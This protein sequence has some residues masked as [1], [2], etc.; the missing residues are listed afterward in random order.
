MGEHLLNKSQERAINYTDGHL[1]I[2]AGAGTGKTTVITKKISKLIN[3]GKAI[4]EQILG[5]TFTE[6]AATEM[7]ERVDEIVSI[8]Y[9]EMQISTFHSFCQLIL[10]KYGLHMGIPDKFKLLTDIDAWLLVKKH[11]YDFELDYYRP[12]GNP[13]CHIHALLKHFSKCKDELISPKEYL[14]YAENALLDGGKINIEEKSRLTELANSY[15]KYNQLLLDNLSLDFSDLIFYTVQLFQMRPN[16]LDLIQEQFKYIFV[17]EFQDVNHAQYELVRLLTKEGK[18]RLTVVGDDDQSIYAFRGASVSNILRFKDDYPNAKEI[19]LTENYR[20]GQEILDSA[21]TLI[22]HN[23]PD[24]L[25]VK[26]KINKKL[27]SCSNTSSEVIHLQKDTLENEAQVVAKKI[28]ELK[29]QD[30]TLSWDDIAILVRANSHA[31]VFMNALDTQGIPYEFLSS[32]GLYRQPIVIDAIN[33]LKVLDSYKESSAIYRLLQLPSFSFSEHDMHEF[34]NFAKKKTISYYEAMKRASEIRLSEEGI[35][36]CKNLVSIITTCIDKVRGEK[37]TSILFCFFEKTGYLSFLMKQE[38]QGNRNA[39]QAI[40]HL[41]Q[42]FDY[43]HSYEISVTNS[44]V[45]GFLEYFET[46]IESGDSGKLYRQAD[47][48]DSVNVM[49]VHG[50]KGLEFRHVFVVNCSEERFPTRRHGE[51]IELPLDLIKEVLPEGDYHYQEERRLFY[52][53]MTRAKEKLF[54]TN[55]EDYGGARKKKVS[56]FIAELGDTLSIDH[57]INKLEYSFSKDDKKNIINEQTFSTKLYALPKT[58]SFSQI[59]AFQTCPY[60]YKILYILK[61]PK[62]GSPYFSFGNTIHITLQEFYKKIQERN[63]VKQ[64]LLFD[65]P[66]RKQEEIEAPTFEELI[67]IYENVWIGDW[68]SDEQQRKEYF[69]K[70]KALLKTFYRKNELRWTI[71]VILEGAFRIKMDSHIITGKIDRVD[72]SSD[73]SLIIIDY[74]TGQAKDKLNGADKQQLL[75]YQKAT[76]ELP[77][78][79]DIGK[80]NS[81]MYYYL[82]EDKQVCFFGSQKDIEKFENKILRTLNTIHET[83]F[84]EINM[85]DGCGRCD[86]C[87]LYI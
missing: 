24:R 29:N 21:Y 33:M 22:T 85:K 71:P 72:K 51:E 20:S 82:A 17:D 68:Y 63:S 44:D 25:E 61:I 45:R 31:T 47:M 75:L 55:S 59:Q 56:R 18:N 28:Y 1:L 26:L 8:G 7:R 14:E 34:L 12:I 69:K 77:L 19:V 48:R 53:A 6:K 64:K 13:S 80:V 78:Y 39:I 4:P 65:L 43:I 16:I 84:R 15:H 40:G 9:V 52:V 27:K 60:Q 86:V 46:V 49:T 30:K 67:E 58:F 57:N 10:E 74:K 79:R 23:N 3:E 41:K 11:L 87:K 37:T 32:G 83:N 36:T 70:G 50:S 73:G 62:K 35:A 66:E 42:F 76:N 5:L 54:L 38:K 81:L 2:V